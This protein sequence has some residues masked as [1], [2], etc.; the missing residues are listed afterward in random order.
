MVLEIALQLGIFLGAG[1]FAFW[2]GGSPERGVATI[3]I[4][5]IV[6][7]QLYHLIFGLSRFDKVDPFH[8]VLDSIELIAISW[9]ALRANRVWP[10]WAAAAQLIC[11][12]GH[13]VAIIESGGMRRA[14]WA[15]TQLPPFVQIVALMGGTVLHA[16]RTRQ[17]GSYRS[18][19]SGEAAA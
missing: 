10:I 4:A 3:V 8:L 7:D 17:I 5:W 2:R 19:R 1:L 16:L 15:M 14:Y 11:V 9:L 6:L 12:A 13:S 18:W